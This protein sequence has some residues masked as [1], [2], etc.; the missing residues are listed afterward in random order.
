MKTIL[1]AGTQSGCGKTTIMLAL[2]QAL[3]AKSEKLVSFKA[4]PDFLDPLW[5][6]VITR[7]ISYNL[8]TRMIGKAECLK[9]MATQAETADCAII[10]GVMGLFDGRSGVG[11]SGSS[12]ELAQRLNVPVILVVDAKGMSGSIVPLV[13]GF[14][15]YA[16]KMQVQIA[17][18][19]ANRVGSAHHAELLSAALQEHKQPPLVAWME[20][21]AP[22][23][24]ERHLGLVAPSEAGVPD[25]SPFF[26]ILDDALTDLFVPPRIPPKKEQ[27]SR[28]LQGKTIAIAKDAA[29][30]FIYPANVDF[31]EQQGAEVVYFSPIKGESIPQTADAVWLPGGYPELFAAQLSVSTT[32][33]SLKEFIEAGKPVLAECGGAMLLGEGLVDLQGKEWKMAGILSYQSQMQ[34]KLASL[35]YREEES[36]IKGHEFHHSIRNSDKELSPC[37]RLDRGDSGVRYKNLRAS[38]VHWYFASAP[39][40]I[41]TWFNEK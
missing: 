18:I 21:S 37:F 11:G 26:H 4:G 32:W 28:Q 13:S 22:S 17:G 30:C 36:G 35:G 2:L 3:K 15:T 27:E 6:Q 39:K 40:V 5:H 29:C 38:Y 25:F 10:E 24:P 20:K 14:V 12:A 33:Q 8:D 1:L 31:L 23:L 19:I 7:R 16:E 9:I 41:A 34:H